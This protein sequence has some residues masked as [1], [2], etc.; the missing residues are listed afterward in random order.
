[1]MTGQQYKASLNDGRRIFLEG[2][3]V[4]DM[5]SHPVYKV[6]VE[7][8]AYLYDRDYDPDPNAIRKTIRTMKSAADLRH[9]AEPQEEED[10]LLAVTSASIMTLLTAAGRIESTLPENAQRIRAWVK[11]AQRRDV[12][13]AQCITDAK[14]DR[15][16]RPSQQDDPD[17][18]VR[19]IERRADGVVIRGAK[20]HITAASLAHELMTIPTKAMKPGEEQ[21]SIACMI[22]TNAPGVRIVDVDY[23]PRHEDARRFPISSRKHMPDSFVIFDDVFVPNERIF[24][25]G[26][27]EFAA[28]FAHSLGLWERIGGLAGMA[29]GYD[30]MVGFA[31]LAAEANGLEK[32]PHIKEKI[33]TMIINATLVRASL[34]AAIDQCGFS[35]DGSAFP[36]ELYTNV[37][38]YHGAANY[39]L[40]VRD[41][42]DIAGGSVQTAPAPADLENEEVGHLIRKYMSTKASIDGEYRTKLFHAIY[43]FT[44]GANGSWA[45]IAQLLSGGGLY[46]QRIVSA[47]RYDLNAAKQQALGAAHMTGPQPAATNKVAS[48]AANSS[49]LPREASTRRA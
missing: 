21:Y 41:L 25:D 2:K 24:L 27:T 20:L 48:E 46:A 4:T 14:G 32:I 1:M 44:A 35:S 7:T 11:E 22:P 39:S 29:R 17:A 15:S 31:Q 40:M 28:V 19:V 5:A 12:R 49:P 6:P 33:S 42:H 47:G 43:D 30:T 13:I 37:G 45:S 8:A 10:I 26:H 9:H 38:K 23:A 34:D 36:H 3:L 16:R 18:Y